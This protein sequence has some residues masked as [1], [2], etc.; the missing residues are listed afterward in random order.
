MRLFKNR[1]RC[2]AAGSGRRSRHNHP[3]P[4]SVRAGRNSVSLA[5][6]GQNERGIV[7]RSMARGPLGQKLVNM[8]FIPGAEVRMIRNAPLRD[9]IEI[10]IQNYM[11]TLRRTEAALIEVESV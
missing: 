11:V 5:E 8:G 7:K 10:G 3:C 6:L 1:E 4:G 2:G 9:P